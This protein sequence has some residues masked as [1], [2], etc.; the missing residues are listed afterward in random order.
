MSQSQVIIVTHSVGMPLRT[1]C[2]YHTPQESA[3][4]AVAMCFNVGLNL[5]TDAFFST[6]CTTVRKNRIVTDF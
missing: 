6:A 3:T 1:A 2:P 4:V 5:F